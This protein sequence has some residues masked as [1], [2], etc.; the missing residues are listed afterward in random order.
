M[1]VTSLTRD[2]EALTLT[3]VADF[4]VSR[5]RLWDAYVD[6]RQIEKFWGPPTYPSTFTRHDAFAGG[7]EPLHHDRPRGRPARW[8]LGVGERGRAA[9]V[10]RHRRLR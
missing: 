10:R 8:V 1:P 2:A 5:Q 9:P 4:A 7:A 6:A 3:V